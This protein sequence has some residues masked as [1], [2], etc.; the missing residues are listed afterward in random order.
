MGETIK[1][2][3]VCGKE[4]PA[5][6]LELSYRRPDVIFN[7]TSE[8]RKERCKE[9]DD[10]CMLDGERFFV[11]GLLA[12][13]VHE[14]DYPYSLGVWA[15][16]DR[17]SFQKIWD[18]WDDPNQG[19]EPPMTGTLANAIP[20]V[21]HTIGLSVLV[22]LSDPDTRPSFEVTESKHQLFQEQQQGISEHRAY[23]YSSHIR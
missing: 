21:V 17:D 12:L 11:R 5:R 8:E 19:K 13:P 16:I 18:L 20:S 15:E 10:I 2:C 22:K 6:E 7:L 1:V 23:E 3:S 4:H 9:N 14:R